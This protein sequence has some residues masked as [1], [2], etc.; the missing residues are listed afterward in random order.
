MK[1]DNIRGVTVISNW[2]RRPRKRP[3]VGPTGSP[4]LDVTLAM[5]TRPFRWSRKNKSANITK[6]VTFRDEAII[7]MSVAG[8][9]TDTSIMEVGRSRP[10]FQYS[11]EELMLIKSLPLSK[12][13]PDFLDTS[14]NNSR[15]VWDP[16]RWHSDRKRSDTPPKDERTGRG[17]QVTENH[18]K[19]RNGDPRERIRKEQDGIVLSPQRRSFNSGCFVNV[20][21][22][23]NRRPESPI[24]KTEVSHREPVRRIGSGRILTRDIWD[25][26][27]ENEKLEPAFR[28]G[29][30]GS[31]SMRDRDNRDTR[32]GKDRENARERDR[33][34]DNLRERDERN[35]RFERRSFGRDYGDRDR[36]RDRDRAA[37]RNDRNH[38][39]ERDKDRGRERRFSNDRR[40]TYSENRCDADE[41]EWF[42]SG[43]TSQHDTIE[44]RGFEDIPEEKAV[45]NSNSNTKNKKQTP[46][47]KKRGKKSS[48]EKDGKQTENSAGPKGRSTPTAMDQPINVVPAP[49]SPISEQNESTSLAQKPNHDSNESA[50]TEQSCETT[51]NS[52]TANQNQENSHPDFNLDEFL[53][54]DTFPG[55]PG[56]L[57]N[58]VGSNGG[59]CSRFSQWFKRESPVQQVDSRR[60][61]IQ[62]DILNNLLNDITEPNIQIP[63]VTESN[64]Y[65][66]P[67]SP[68]NTTA[69]NN[70]TSTTGVKLLEMLQRG[71]KPS[72]NG[73][74]D[75]ASTVIPMMKSSSIKDMEVGGKV[76]HSLEELEARMR[77]GAPP[78]T[79]STDQP[80]VNKTEEDLSAFK[81][82]LAQ[83]T[84]GQAIPA[85]NG[86]ISQKQP[87]TLIQ[88]LNSQLKTQAIAPQQ[89]VPEPMHAT[90]FNHA[91]SVGPTQH[92]HQAQMQHENLMKVLQIQQQQQKQQQQQQQQQQAQQRA[93]SPV[94]SPAKQ[95]MSPTPLAFTP[96]SVLRKMTADKEPEGNSSDPSKLTAQS[97]TSQMQQMQSAVQLLTQ[98]V[99]CRHNTLR[100]QSVQSTWSNPTIKQHPGRPIVKGGS[101]GSNGS[102]QFQYS[103]NSDFQQQQQ[104][105][106]QQH[107]TV[108]SVYGN[109]ARSKHTMT[110]SIPHHNVPQYNV[111]QNS[112]INQRSNSM[113]NQMKVQQAPSHLANMQHQPP[114]QQQR[115][116]NSQMQMVLNQNYNSNR[117]DGRVM[118]SQ[119]L[120]MPVGRQASPGLGYVGSNGGDLSP[121]SNQLAR[122]FSPELLAQAR[123]GKLPELVQTNV[124]SLEELERLQHASTTVHN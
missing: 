83:V 85:A 92:P 124:L 50:V 45:N 16:E 2:Y 122:W 70:T 37:E 103:A 52:S 14:Y 1:L 123:A 95:T 89:S 65:F 60:T 59:S 29:A 88:L 74:G 41:P 43:P 64:T 10:Q 19:R 30:S 97:Q 7:S 75:A 69:T 107:R 58:G 66:A 12:R 67:I 6:R 112:M 47:Q 78:P 94:N 118:R 34:R 82:L 15:G 71:N 77:G 99:L 80:R 62:D 8:E 100:P 23:S 35:E 105:Q 44:L 38:Q 90:T 120:N 46:V 113:N 57:T 106:Q 27:P 73:Q 18:N 33:D 25:F 63:S 76:V 115:I 13:R 98:G 26:R 114:Q 53:K 119:Q 96:T 3:L 102:N 68:A 87:V 36:E 40:R 86:P 11:R 56:L 109:P 22:P 93:S 81:K 111:A 79:S 9:V 4:L 117:A 48:L 31:T 55:V 21:Q 5:Q 84:G 61:S 42:S 101:G 17:D 39:S 91:G 54:S 116:L 32:D 104:Q 121:T 28:S 49:H 20:N 72:Q 24:G 108:S 51:D 110:S